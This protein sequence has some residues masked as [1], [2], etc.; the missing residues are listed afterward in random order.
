MYGFGRQLLVPAGVHPPDAGHHSS[1]GYALHG[2]PAHYLGPSA[3]SL[4]VIP[5][6]VTLSHYLSGH[7]SLDQCTE[8]G[9]KGISFVVIK[10]AL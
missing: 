4:T 6:D 9:L 3:C 7:V 1:R 2:W 8:W 10:A 5:I